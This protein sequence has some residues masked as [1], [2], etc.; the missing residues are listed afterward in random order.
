[1]KA[2]VIM[3]GVI[4]ILLAAT[5]PLTCQMVSMYGPEGLRAYTVEAEWYDCTRDE[6]LTAEI[7]Y[8]QPPLITAGI[9]LGIALAA[10]G[11]ACF[12]AASIEPNGVSR[13]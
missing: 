3:I 1:M 2:I 13:S 12:I 8:M 5:M 11:V 6:Q 9:L 7:K 4:L 10:G